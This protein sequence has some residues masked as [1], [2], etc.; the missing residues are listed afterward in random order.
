DQPPPSVI[1]LAIGSP[2]FALSVGARQI[3]ITLGFYDDSGGPLLAASET[4]PTGQGSTAKSW[5]T[6]N[7]GDITAG[8]AVDYGK[9]PGITPLPAGTTLLGL[10]VAVT[11]PASAPGI[12]QAPA[13]LGMADCPWPAVRI[14]PQPIWDAVASRFVIRY[15]RL[16]TLRIARIH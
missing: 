2:L 13:G 8:A 12:G 14:V 5:V 6:P 1:G 15:P 4:A 9:L 7:S 10:R 11:L 3:V 16:H